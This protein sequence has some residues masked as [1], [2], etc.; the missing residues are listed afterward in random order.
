M[1]RIHEQIVFAA[2]PVAVATTAT[3]CRATDGTQLIGQT[4]VE[5]SE[6]CGLSTVVG[7]IDND[8]T[9]VTF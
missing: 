5:Q 6:L 2:S 8:S 1:L 7:L 4:L 9:V 3:V